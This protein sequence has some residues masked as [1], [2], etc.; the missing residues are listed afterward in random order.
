MTAEFVLSWKFPPAM[1]VIFF[2][3]ELVSAVIEI[4]LPAFVI[5]FL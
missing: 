2:Y 4:S 1:L 3:E 5:F